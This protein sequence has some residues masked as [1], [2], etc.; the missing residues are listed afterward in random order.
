MPS[1]VFSRSLVSGGLVGAV[2]VGS[3]TIVPA[4]LNG[5]PRSGG[6]PVIAKPV[7]SPA[8]PAAGRPFT[9]SFKVTR[10][11]NGRPFRS[12]RMTGDP[13]SDDSVTDSPVSE[14]SV[15]SGA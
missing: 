6:R 7:A 4:A 1:R 12:G 2:L 15:K 11:D 13:L 10:S 14:S 8:Q 3:L 9:A 5:T